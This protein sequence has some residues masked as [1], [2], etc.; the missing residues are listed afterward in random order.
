[1]LTDKKL[2]LKVFSAIKFNV[3]VQVRLC[4]AHSGG[5]SPPL[6]LSN[7]TLY[8]NMCYEAM[9]CKSDAVHLLMHLSKVPGMM[10]QFYSP[11]ELASA[12]LQG[13]AGYSAAVPRT[14]PSRSGS[15]RGMAIPGM[16]HSSVD[17]SA[18]WR[19]LPAR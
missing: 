19:D 16:V 6:P 12:K 15:Q 11:E 2:Q 7:C 18:L 8:L 17:L 10:L 14:P 5:A 3:L 4:A 1:M 13:L 9:R